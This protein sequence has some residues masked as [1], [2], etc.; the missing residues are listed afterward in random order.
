MARR[1]S[2]ERQKIRGARAR[3]AGEGIQISVRELD[4]RLFEE[5]LVLYADTV[6]RMRHGVN[7]ALEERDTILADRSSYIALCASSGARLVGCCLA[8]REPA[9]DTVR[10]RFSAADH[11]HRETSLARVL[12]MEAG[13][14][15][16]ELEHRTLSL[17]KDRNLYGHIAKPGLLRF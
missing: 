14:V 8:R 4:E 10:V 9:L 12:Y 3:T 17:G 7:V 13:R 1:S 5:F 16:R 2:A 11:P 6:N 15:T